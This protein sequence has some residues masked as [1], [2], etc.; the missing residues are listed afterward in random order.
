MTMA[1][2]MRC[3]WYWR[4]ERAQR[5]Y[6]VLSEQQRRNRGKG[7]LL[8]PLCSALARSPKALGLHLDPALELSGGVGSSLTF[9]ELQSGL[10]RLRRDQPHAAAGA[11]RLHRMRSF[12]N[13]WV[14][15]ANDPRKQ[16]CHF[17]LY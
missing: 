12:A 4:N 11:V 16:R 13:G 2:E 8:R 10:E 6:L 14:S 5:V 1:C 9:S 15:S 7:C 3:P 17:L